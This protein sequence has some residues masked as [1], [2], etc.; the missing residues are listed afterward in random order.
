MKEKAERNAKIGRQYYAVLNDAQGYPN[1][2][3]YWEEMSPNMKYI[4][5]V[6]ALS[7]LEVMDKNGVVKIQDEIG[8]KGVFGEG[9]CAALM[10][11]LVE[12]SE[13]QLEEFN[14][15]VRLFAEKHNPKNQ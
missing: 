8:V 10:E 13:E 15:K 5:T 11:Y 4:Y 1:G 6:T 2:M 7:F 12:S 14:E 9:D 3:Q